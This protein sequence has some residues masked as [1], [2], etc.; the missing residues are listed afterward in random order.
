MPFHRESLKFYRFSLEWD[1]LA[2]PVSRGYFPLFLGGPG[3]IRKVQS[4]LTELRRD[5][6]I[7]LKS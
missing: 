1:A 6:A 4:R 5:R 7:G 3:R 2:V